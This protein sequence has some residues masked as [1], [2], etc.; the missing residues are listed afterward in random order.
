MFRIPAKSKNRRKQP[1]A[2][3]HADA[4]AAA[5]RAQSLA[6]AALVLGHGGRTQPREQEQGDNIGDGPAPRG[7]DNIQKTSK[8]PRRLGGEGIGGAGAQSTQAAA[9]YVKMS[10]REVDARV[11]APEKL[12]HEQLQAQAKALGAVGHDALRTSY[13]SVDEYIRT[14][15]PPLLEEAREGIRREFQ[16]AAEQARAVKACVVHSTK[17]VLPTGDCHASWAK[18]TARTNAPTNLD[19]GSVVVVTSH[20]PPTRGMD[21]V[22]S[23]VAS[24]RSKHQDAFFI[25]AGFC[26]ANVLGSHGDVPVR[27]CVADEV[28]KEAPPG[29]ALN[30]T[31]YVLH[32]GPLA[33]LRREMQ[34][35]QDV[36]RLKS[37]FLEALL[38]PTATTRSSGAGSPPE[39]PLYDQFREK[40]E[41][42]F[43]APQ[44]EALTSAACAADY[45]HARFSSFNSNYNSQIAVGSYM[46]ERFSL[47]R[48]PPGTGKSHCVWGLINV[49]HTVQFQRYHANLH[50]TLLRIDVAARERAAAA[51]G[52]EEMMDSLTSVTQQQKPRLLVCAPSNAAIDELVSRVAQRGF[53][54]NTGRQYFP[55]IA[56]VGG[57]NAAL[58]QTASEVAVETRVNRFLSF[59]EQQ[60]HER[61][62]WL[63]AECDRLDLRM[64]L[65]YEE[66]RRR[67]VDDVHDRSAIGGAVDTPPSP[68]LGF[69]AT[70]TVETPSSPPFSPIGKSAR[71]IFSPHKESP[72]AAS[73]PDDNARAAAPAP[74]PAAAADVATRKQEPD[75]FFGVFTKD[76]LVMEFFQA[77]QSKDRYVTE[78]KQLFLLKGRW[79]VGFDEQRCHD[80]LEALIMDNA[81]VVFT[82]LSMSSKR[83]FQYLNLEFKTVVIDEAGQ[84]TEVAALQPLQYGCEHCI[85]VGDPM[86]L[87]ATV[88][89]RSALVQR[90][91]F[92]RSLFERLQKG[93]GDDAV[94]MLS[95]Q[96]R[97]HPSIREFPSRHFYHD[98]LTDG[99]RVMQAAQLEAMSRRPYQ[100]DPAYGPLRFFNVSGK[101]QRGAPGNSLGNDVEASVVASLVVAVLVS[102]APGTKVAAITPYRRQ[103]RLVEDTCRRFLLARLNGLRMQI[104][105]LRS[106]GIV[107]E[108]APSLEKVA[109][110][111]E[112]HLSNLSVNTVDAFQ[113]KEADVVV[114]SCVRSMIGRRN[115]PPPP[116]DDEECAP[117]VE[118]AIGF[119]ADT[120]RMNVALT[121]AKHSLWVCGHAPTLE[122]YGGPSWRA[123]LNHTK[124]AR[125]FVEDG[126]TY[127]GRSIGEQQQQQQ[128][129][130]VAALRR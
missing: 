106:R 45:F 47:I 23:W 59:T 24:M 18:V 33:T 110:M 15:V 86:Q 79:T 88:L 74:A 54:D 67:I 46:P 119:L 85:C 72:D 53:V 42:M 65:I 17:H 20:L 61:W 101:E 84:C 103:K 43:N 121:R 111:C 123:F 39:L 7:A 116:P 96:Y 50:R 44:L 102:A 36:S 118:S 13:R 94:H 9:T 120:R 92:E 58:S 38:R 75:P 29:L 2:D 8:R 70:E 104:E 12:F 109:S 57:Q 99:E 71:P 3:A 32:G 30:S 100:I 48:G 125:C 81:E 31:C 52:Q 56:R 73:P 87:A 80:Q 16:E 128:Q 63:Q 115:I 37:P 112:E 77:Y 113:G 107:K 5:S 55:V 10:D 66:L 97:M 1:A 68:S 95:V 14:F 64:K 22:V 124:T 91:G 27:L 78:S 51:S 6:A 122:L 69:V 117:V 11:L 35:L 89:S 105:L 40:F 62:M 25:Y 19:R 60:C 83:S 114:I 93:M 4:A 130:A 82:T 41:P 34:A 129:H 49:L 90:S 26:D 21:S 108:E 127:V 126:G 76:Q 98:R 28:G